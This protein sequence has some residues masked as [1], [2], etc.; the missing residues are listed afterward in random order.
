M[1]RDRQGYL[2]AM[3]GSQ[4]S[5]ADASRAGTVCCSFCLKDKDSV[6]KL[7]A[8]LGVYICNEC[9]ELCNL[10]IAQEPDQA[11]AP[12]SRAVGWD[13]QPDDA[14]L[15]NLGRLQAVV[16]QVDAALHHHVGML[17][18][19][20]DL[21]GL[22]DAL[23]AEQRR[24]VEAHSRT[25]AEMLEPLGADAPWLV[26]AT[27]SHHERLDGTGYPD[28]LRGH[29]VSALTRLLAVCDVYAAFCGARPHRPARPT[30]PNCSR[31]PRL[32]M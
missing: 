23:N 28:G 7:V 16:S 15:A 10:I 29:Q 6:A 26:E 2:D 4:S 21:L 12:A 5:T 24:A 17:R 14:L 3:T 1:R 22:T 18:A 27:L 32:R 30:R 20:A 19:P 11:S 25:G 31:L 13:E 9:V 8:G